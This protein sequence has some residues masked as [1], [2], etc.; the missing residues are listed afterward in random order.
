MF[1]S[2]VLTMFKLHGMLQH[3]VN[4][5]DTAHGLDKYCLLYDVRK[6]IGD[7]EEPYILTHQ[8]IPYCIRLSNES[9]LDED[10]SIDNTIHNGL[11]FAELRA[12]N[13][14]SKQLLSW[15]ATIGLAE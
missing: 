9:I 4:M 12:K 2:L 14:S 7:Y 15:S 10:I 3:Q 6:D 11:K 8:V 1:L 13:I 5:Y